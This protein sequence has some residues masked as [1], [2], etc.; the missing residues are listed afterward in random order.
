MRP[1]DTSPE[2][3]RIYVDICRQM[4]PSEKLAKTFELSE[5]CRNELKA[6]LRERHPKADEREIFLRCA[7]ISLGLEL[8]ER[9]YGEVSFEVAD[10]PL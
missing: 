9:A 2:I 7:R 1:A 3:W 5:I 8:F 10:Q 4:T 6:G